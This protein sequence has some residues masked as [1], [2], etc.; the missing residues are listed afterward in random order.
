MCDVVQ[1]SKP[2]AAQAVGEGR[3]AALCGSK[4]TVMLKANVMF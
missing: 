4:P 3:G 1:L 2:G